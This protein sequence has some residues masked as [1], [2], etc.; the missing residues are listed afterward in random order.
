MLSEIGNMTD[1][2]F[3]SVKSY[4]PLSVLPPLFTSHTFP[5]LT[6]AAITH[7]LFLLVSLSNP[8]SH[9]H[10]PSSIFPPPPWPGP[11]SSPS[12]PSLYS[13]HLTSVCSRHTSEPLNSQS[14]TKACSL[15]H[16]MW[17]S[18]SVLLYRSGNVRATVYLSGVIWPFGRIDTGLIVKGHFFFPRSKVSLF[19]IVHIVQS[20]LSDPFSKS[21]LPLKFQ[22]EC[23]HR[24]YWQLQITPLC[25]LSLTPISFQHCLCLCH[26]L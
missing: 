17:L 22:K 23:L 26:I 1:V 13:S 21:L 6:P 8:K 15:G 3:F 2:T 4:P 10:S 20:E 11:V 24:K 7:L 16:I 25:T 19:L 18:L 5:P 14:D 12:P 9:S